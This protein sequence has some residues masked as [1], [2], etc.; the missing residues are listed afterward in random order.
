MARRVRGLETEYGLSLRTRTSTGMWRR[1]G[2]DEAARQ[3][4]LPVVEA[5]AATNVFLRNGGR[6][7]LDIGSHPEYATAECSS[8]ADLIRQDRAGDAIV[9]RLADR[10][11]EALAEEGVEAKVA[12]L[13]NNVDSHGNSYGSHENYQ[14]D[15]REDY[16]ELTAAMT[17]FLVT[18]QL[19]CG[20]GRVI[21]DRRGGVRFELSQRAEH[22]WDP[23]S[24][25][26]TRSRPLI[27]TRDEPHADPQRFRRLHVI[28]GDSTLAQP[29]LL[30][31]I[32]STELVLAAAEDG[33]DF[34][35]M[36][37]DDPAAAIRAVS[38]D[39]TG[40]TRVRLASGEEIAAVEL[41]RR[42]WTRL[43]PFGTDDAELQAAHEL[44]G[45]VLD[46]VDG[47]CPED[48]AREIDW[49][50][51][52]RVLTAWR[53]RHG[54]DPARL[55]QLDLAWHDIRPGGL[56][57]LAEQRAQ[58][59]RLVGDDEI[60]EAVEQPPA[61]TRAHLRGRLLRAAQQY[62]RRYSCDWMHFTVTDL[63][64]GALLCP[65]PASDD[66][67]RVDALIARM[68]SEPHTAE[69]GRAFGG[70]VPAP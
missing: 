3:L 42:I 63:P 45:R 26:T 65:D 66:D 51:K 54:D 8:I 28:V 41:Q 24:S 15:R 1:V 43:E 38:R 58:V 29:T 59:D 67:E 44:W 6:L 39:T 22:M 9:N 32:G 49:A 36:A 69:T 52:L 12:I 4:F 5:N 37:L 34:S 14:I 62:H 16:D 55:A 18:R 68:A 40:R 35:D 33:V 25:A 17:P 21:R 57:G 31:R 19:I 11:V 23:V 10:A 47:R 27:N 53:D 70:G 56:F 50:A 13:K 46:A 7:Y 2:S 64:D 60:A 61:D 20:A 48:V 30:V